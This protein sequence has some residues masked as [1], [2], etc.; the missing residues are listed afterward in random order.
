MNNKFQKRYQ[1]LLLQQYAFKGSYLITEWNW[2]DAWDSIKGYIGLGPSK[3]EQAAAAAEQAAQQDPNNRIIQIAQQIS[4]QDMEKARQAIATNPQ[5]HAHFSKITD[6]QQ[7]RYFIAN[8]VAQIKAKEQADA[9]AKEESTFN[10]PEG[11]AGEMYDIIEATWGSEFSEDKW[12]IAASKKG[13]ICVNK[14]GKPYFV[15]LSKFNKH[16]DKYLRAARKYAPKDDTLEDDFEDTIADKPNVKQMFEIYIE[17]SGKD[18]AAATADFSAKYKKNEILFI[19][20]DGKPS[21]VTVSEFD[22]KPQEFIDKAKDANPNKS[23]RH[24]DAK[25]NQKHLDAYNKQVADLLKNKPFE[26]SDAKVERYLDN[27]KQQ[28][29]IL[30]LVK[31]GTTQESSNKLISEN[32]ITEGFLADLIAKWNNIA[33]DNPRVTKLKNEYEFKLLDV[34]DFAAKQTEY[35]DS[36]EELHKELT[37]EKADEK[38]E[39]DKKEADAQKKAE[40]L[41]KCKDYQNEFPASEVANNCDTSDKNWHG[42]AGEDIKLPVGTKMY[43]WLGNESAKWTISSQIDSKEEVQALRTFLNTGWNSENPAHPMAIANVCKK[44]IDPDI[45]DEDV[46]DEDEFKT[47]QTLCKTWIGKAEAIDKDY[48]E[49]KLK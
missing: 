24:D 37:K 7:Q 27:A 19:D 28:K 21:T 18:Q 35:M 2:A 1:Q 36:I 16:A 41:Q 25:I 44:L 32:I 17:A 22:Q 9:K 13:V 5:L 15:A 11:K 26:F 42:M 31:K 49:F 29:K 12:K 38:A 39:S 10:K 14:K 34:K 33:K 3:A 8:L 40:F 6:P 45:Q 30:C 4:D 46:F 43:D 47:L 23:R 20:T 48:P